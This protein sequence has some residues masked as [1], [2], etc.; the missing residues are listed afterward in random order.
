MS[1]S[2]SSIARWRSSIRSTATALFLLF[3]AASAAAQIP[4]PVDV[5]LEEALVLRADG[6]LTSAVSFHHLALGFHLRRAHHHLRI[7]ARLGNGGG[8]AE[9]DAYLVRSIG[10]DAKESDEVARTAFE[11]SYPFADWVEI[12]EDIDLEAGQYWLILAKPKESNWSSINWFATDF[13]HVTHSCNAILGNAQSFTFQ[14]DEADYVPASKFER[15]YTPYT[16]QVEMTE[17]RLA[18]SADPCGDTVIAGK[19]SSR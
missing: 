13:A 4:A 19:R 18:G 2:G 5:P 12:F 17:L 14:S 7:A 1:H 15:K 8:R 3:G 11:L 16:Y 10:P 6:E 9:V